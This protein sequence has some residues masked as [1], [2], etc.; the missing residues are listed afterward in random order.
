MATAMTATQWPMLTALEPY[1]WLSL[2]ILFVGWLGTFA[3]CL[4]DAWLNDREVPVS[5][6]RLVVIAVAFYGL[7]L[8]A[9]PDHGRDLLR[10]VSS[11]GI[12]W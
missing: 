3:F 11:P 6:W 2:V 7:Y 12:G 9:Q 5:R 8:A 1:F 10:A 4:A